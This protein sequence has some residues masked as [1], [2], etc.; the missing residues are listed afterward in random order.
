MANEIDGFLVE[1]ENTTTI[2]LAS[3][4]F[5]TT[6]SE[7]CLVSANI[8]LIYTVSIVKINRAV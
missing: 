7:V 1:T 5:T 6:N 4:Y 2:R 8:A 3:L